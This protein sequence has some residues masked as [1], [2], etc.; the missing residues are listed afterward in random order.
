MY[1]GD[2]VSNKAMILFS[3]HC[4]FSFK[5][6]MELI[7]ITIILI[8]KAICPKM[9][10]FAHKLLK[11]MVM[12]FQKNDTKLRCKDSKIFDGC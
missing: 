6:D 8:F 10:V 2:L 12:K 7:R 1:D 11:I 5:P 4:F 3:K 9:P